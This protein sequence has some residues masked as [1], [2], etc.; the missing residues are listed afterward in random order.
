MTEMEVQA[1][2]VRIY[3]WNGTSWQQKGTDIDGEAADD[4]QVFGEY[5]GCEYRGHWRT[6]K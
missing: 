6:Q 1:G 5:A 4:N 2:H 3:V